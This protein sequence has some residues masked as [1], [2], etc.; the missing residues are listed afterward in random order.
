[1]PEIGT[2]KIGSHILNLHIKRPN[3]AINKGIGSLKKGNFKSHV[4]K[5]ADN[6][7]LTY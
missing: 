4:R 3:L 7:T 5:I 6:R 2:K 1:M